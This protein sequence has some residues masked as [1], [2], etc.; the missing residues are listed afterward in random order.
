MTLGH[1]DRGSDG[2][3]NLGLNLG[4]VFY[5]PCELRDSLILCLLTSLLHGFYYLEYS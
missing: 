2:G 4:F 1:G 3:Q 5:L